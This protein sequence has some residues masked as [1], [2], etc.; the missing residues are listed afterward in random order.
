MTVYLMAFHNSIPLNST[1]H[2]ISKKYEGLRP[3]LESLPNSSHT[4]RDLFL[5]PDIVPDV[6][7]HLYH[8]RQPKDT[9]CTHVLVGAHPLWTNLLTPNLVGLRIGERSIHLSNG[10]SNPSSSVTRGVTFEGFTPTY[11]ITAYEILWE[12][13]ESEIGGDLAGFIQRTVFQ[14]LEMESAEF[15][16]NYEKGSLPERMALPE[17]SAQVRLD[18]IGKSQSMI[19]TLRDYEKFLR[20]YKSLVGDARWQTLVPRASWARSAGQILT[21]EGD[22]GVSSHQATS[23]AQAICIDNGNIVILAAEHG[24]GRTHPLLGSVYNFVNSS[25]Y[26]LSQLCLSTILAPR[27]PEST[28]RCVVNTHIVDDEEEG[29]RGSERGKKDAPELT[30]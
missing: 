19:C 4:L 24:P 11:N 29:G 23:R 27:K 26:S 18:R 20:G 17:S 25:V 9:Y 22:H 15:I 3:L 30:F 16:Y 28:A 6:L 2:E 13:M 21:G 8:L 12:I 5:S 14:P 7:Y 10:N 1:I